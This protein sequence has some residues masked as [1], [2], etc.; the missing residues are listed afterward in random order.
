MNSRQMK[1][2]MK[3]MGI[4]QQEVDN[5]LEVIIK[6][7]DKQIIISDPQVSKV[8]M[9]GQQTWQI[10]GN[11]REEPLDSSP[12]ISDEDVQTVMQQTGKGEEEVRN[13][14]E[15]NKGNLAETIIELQDK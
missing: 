12:E 7:K 2:A 13:A 15:K 14:L 3:R 8:N 11:S 9:M 6:C 1:M 10:T 5:A 4:Q